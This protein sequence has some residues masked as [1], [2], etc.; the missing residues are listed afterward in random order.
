MKQYNRK[1]EQQRGKDGAKA[2]TR[3]KEKK[4][5][6]AVFEKDVFDCGKV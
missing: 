4:A 2:Q 6:K 1:D 3:R 5:T